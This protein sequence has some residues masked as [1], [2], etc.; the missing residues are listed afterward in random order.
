MQ[1]DP[2]LGDGLPGN[3]REKRPRSCKNPNRQY[4]DYPRNENQSFAGFDSQAATKK[5]DR[6]TQATKFGNPVSRDFGGGLDLG[7]KNPP[8]RKKKAVVAVMMVFP[9]M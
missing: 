2:V 3:K 6:R 1:P 5:E 7:M 9:M 8:K 4:F